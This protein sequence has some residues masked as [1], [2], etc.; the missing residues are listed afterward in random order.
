MKHR[1]KKKRENYSLQRKRYLCPT[2]KGTFSRGKRIFLG[3]K[4][5][6]LRGG[7]FLEAISQGSRRP[8]GS[9]MLRVFCRESRRRRRL[10]IWPFVGP[11][12]YATM[13]SFVRLVYQRCL[14]N[15]SLYGGAPLCLCSPRGDAGTRATPFLAHPNDTPSCL[16]NSGMPLRRSYKG[17][18]SWR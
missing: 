18:S 4:E 2:R 8:G 11:R 13:P 10:G 1:L 5:G 16:W 9:G 12:K 3:E 14:P 15:K 17:A 6:I 7:T